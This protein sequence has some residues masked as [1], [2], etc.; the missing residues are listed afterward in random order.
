MTK[1]QRR[2]GTLFLS[3]LVLAAVAAVAWREWPRQPPTVLTLYGNIDIRQVDLAFN[4]I[5]RV[6]EMRKEEGDHVTTGELLARI[7][8]QTYADLVSL[9]QARVDAQRAAVQRLVTGSR[10][11]E[12]ARDR[13]SVESAQA[14]L[15]NADLL[16]TRRTE[17]LKSGGVSREIY[18]ETKAADDMARARLK[19]ATQVSRLTDIGPRQED[20]DEAKATLRAE[21]SLLALAQRRLAE[22]ELKAPANGIILSRIVEPGTM[23]SATNPVYTLS[24][25][26]KVWVRAYIGEPDLGRVHPG[27]EVKVSSDGDPGRLY[28]GW[29]GF[30]SPT[31]EFTP[32]TVETTEL[33]T[34]L[35]YRLRVFIR[36][37]D[38]R[39][40]QGMPVTVHIALGP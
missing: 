2:W 34:Q 8:P 27:L 23:A 36:N 18:E 25:T 32:K 4:D 17:L 15:V 26:D 3:L 29:V 24:L 37:P 5:G 33:R 39:L 21:E 7:E 10:P 12:I 28:D 22:T 40:R 16:L 20:I 35:V 31:A 6:I 9:S 14:D 1:T 13:A 11:E 38:E 30:V 19:V